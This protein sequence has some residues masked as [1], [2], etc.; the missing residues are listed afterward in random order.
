M[1]CDDVIAEL[2]KRCLSFEGAIEDMPWEG[3]FGWKVKGKLFAIGGEGSNRVT[4]KSTPDKQAAL[5]QLEGVER[6]AYVGRF[7]WVTVTIEDD[8]ALELA[9]G[10]IGESYEAAAKKG[11]RK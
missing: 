1:T 6:A 2:R 7:G 5:I 11:R 8:T 9:K 4:V 10:L 3:H